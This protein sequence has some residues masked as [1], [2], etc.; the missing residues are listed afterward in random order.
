M[1]PIDTLELVKF[2]QIKKNER[3][4]DWRQ[5]GDYAINQLTAEYNK[6]RVEPGVTGNQTL[7]NLLLTYLALVDLAADAGN[8]EAK[9]RNLD[10]S[11]WA[12][13]P[14]SP[15]WSIT[16]IVPLHALI[17]KTIGKKFAR[18]TWYPAYVTKCLHQAASLSNASQVTEI[19][20]SSLGDKESTWS[21][22]LEPESRPNSFSQLEWFSYLLATIHKKVKVN[23]QYL[24]DSLAKQIKLLI[25]DQVELVHCNEIKKSMVEVILT[26]MIGR[27]VYCLSAAH[28]SLIWSCNP[29]IPLDRKPNLPYKKVFEKFT[30]TILDVSLLPCDDSTKQFLNDIWTS[31][32]Q[33]FYSSVM[34]AHASISPGD[35]VALTELLNRKDE[36]DSTESIER[37]LSEISAYWNE[38]TTECFVSA[39]SLQNLDGI[40]EKARERYEIREISPSDITV[41]YDPITHY[42]IGS[43]SEMVA[44]KFVR[45]IKPGYIKYR[46]NGSAKVI[47]KALV[48]IIDD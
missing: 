42:L 31:T 21:L 8:S 30:Q 38:R 17:L 45:V 19:A 27:P 26:A 10:T 44:P 40:L 25:I 7:K 32:A 36:I 37:L 6:L 4:D 9:R 1:Q 29:D 2:F 5:K 48:E 34:V 41:S 43:N 14:P 24:S 47:R 12:D 20:F 33:S 46:E 18:R 3:T 39:P 15:V 35:R 22:I 11:V 16:D 28:L 13:E 23:P